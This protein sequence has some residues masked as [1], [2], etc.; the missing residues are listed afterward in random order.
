M[1]NRLQGGKRPRS[2]MAP[3]LV[4]DRAPDGARGA[5]RVVTGSPGGAAII[6]FVAQ[7]LLA[8]LDG[9]MVGR[10]DAQA[11]TALPH[12]AA[13]NTPVTVL[14]RDHPDTAALAALEAAL[15]AR[16]HR[17]VRA[18]LTSGVATI[19]RVPGIYAA[20]RAGGDPRERV[21]RGMPVLVPADD[22]YTNHVHADDLARACIAALHRGRPQRIVH[23]CDDGTLTM[24]EHFDLV[25]DLSGLPRP[26]RITR[27]QA[28]RE[29]SPMT[30]SFLAESRR[31]DNRRL[32][33]ELKLR[34]RYPTV[35]EG[36]AGAPP[37][38]EPAPPF[39]SVAAP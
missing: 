28:E 4:F 17:V 11:A 13:F 10:M 25:A 16:G 7:T 36:L 18:P 12:V 29:L 3:T 34:L 32:K 14:E 30:L 35:R 26:R 9:P 8:L 6:P 19:L 15:Q 23:V 21:R 39:T 20:D 1:A 24:G 33:L 27:E 2:S 38:A 37:A 5:L 31:L 22:V